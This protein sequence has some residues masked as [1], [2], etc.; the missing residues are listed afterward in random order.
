MNLILKA[1]TNNV[2]FKHHARNKVRELGLDGAVMY[3]L[4][5]Y[6][7][8]KSNTIYEKSWLYMTVYSMMLE[9]TVNEIGE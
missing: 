5:K 7:Y 1:T 9:Y 8:Y 6:R 3:F 2:H 4:E